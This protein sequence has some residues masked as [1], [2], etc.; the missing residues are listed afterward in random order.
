MYCSYSVINWEVK[1]GLEFKPRPLDFLYVSPT[2]ETLI[3]CGKLCF[4]CPVLSSK[5]LILQMTT[6][7]KSGELTVLNIIVRYLTF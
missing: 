3:C 7:L 6:V 5:D 4:D 1:L 2:V